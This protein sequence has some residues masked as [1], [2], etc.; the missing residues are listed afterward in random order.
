MGHGRHGRQ[1]RRIMATVTADV[2]TTAAMFTVAD[3]AAAA[4][5][6]VDCYRCCW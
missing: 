5:I 6:V 1:G 4:V 3:A 2:F